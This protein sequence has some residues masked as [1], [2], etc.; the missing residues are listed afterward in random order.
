M[1]KNR[2]D[3]G[4]FGYLAL[5]GVLA[6]CG[7]GSSSHAQDAAPAAGADA[8]D[9]VATPDAAL[10]SNNTCVDGGAVASSCTSKPALASVPDLSGIWILETI[11]AQ[12]VTA[13]GYAQPFH[14]KSLSVILAQVLQTGNAV[15][16]AGQYC[17]RIQQDD[18]RNPA[19]V[20]IPDA[21]RLTRSLYERSGTFA[22][23]EAGI[24][25]LK[26]PAYVEVFGARLSDLA[27]ESL[28][29]EPTDLRM[30]DEDNDGSQGLSV[31]L[32]GLI[33]GALRSVQRQSTALTGL[34]VDSTRIEGGMAY[35][36]DQSVVDSS[37]IG[38]KTLYAGSKAFA[39]PSDCASTFVMVKVPDGTN[40]GEVDCT[41]VRANE[42][43]LLGL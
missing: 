4:T 18:P 21:W 24:W 16:F 17:D 8:S 26:M 2:N 40:G 11:G 32:S 31:Q 30:V 9:P 1:T 14:I 35:L 22:A 7:G 43:A 28:P 6:G 37:P 36:S 29:V 10:A 27:C 33:S 15:T 23:D 3:L 20:V 41:W 5:A 42:T 39:D 38:I 13:P 12:V 19:K 25:T 34:V